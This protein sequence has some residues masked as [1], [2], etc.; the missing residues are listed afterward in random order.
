MEFSRKF[1]QTTGYFKT[2]L[3][4]K[5]SKCKPEDIKKNYEEWI[6]EHNILRGDLQKCNVNIDN[7]HMITHKLSNLPEEYQTIV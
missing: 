7:S 2:I 1:E 5:F 6:T 4:N 3:H